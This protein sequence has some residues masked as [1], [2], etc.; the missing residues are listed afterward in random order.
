MAGRSVGSRSALFWMPADDRKR[1]TATCCRE[2]VVAGCRCIMEYLEGWLS[3]MNADRGGAGAAGPISC[4]ETRISGLAKELCDDDYT[5]L[6]NNSVRPSNKLDSTLSRE[7]N[8]RDE[9]CILNW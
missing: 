1:G 2:L 3:S 6:R 4:C 7:G 9:V 5:L 8:D